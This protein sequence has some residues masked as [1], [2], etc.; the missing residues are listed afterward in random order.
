GVTGTNVINTSCYLRTRLQALNNYLFSDRFHPLSTYTFNRRGHL[1]KYIYSKETRLGGGEVVWQA[2]VSTASSYSSGNDDEEICNAPYNPSFHFPSADLAI[3]TNGCGTL[4]LLETGDRNNTNTWLEAF[5]GLAPAGEVVHSVLC[6]GPGHQREI[7]TL[8]LSV[9][10]LNTLKQDDRFVFMNSQL[11]NSKATALHLVHW[12]TL[13]YNGAVWEK[14]RER[15]LCGEG[16]LEYLSLNEA[17]TGILMLAHNNYSF[18]YDS[19]VKLIKPDTPIEKKLS[20][21]DFMYTQESDSV[22]IWVQLSSSIAKKDLNVNIK[23]SEMSISVQDESLLQG[24]FENAIKV[25]ESTWTISE[26][27]LELSLTKANESLQWKRVFRSSELVGEELLDPTMVEE[28]HQRLAH[29]TTDKLNANPDADKPA[30]NPEQLEACDEATDDLLL[31]RLD[32][33]THTITHHAQLGATQHLFNGQS[34]EMC[35]PNFCIRHDVDGL[36]WQPESA[37]SVHHVATFNAFG[38]VRA[39]KSM[40]KFTKAS[41]DNSYVAVADVKSHVYVFYQTDSLG[42]EIR[43]RKS[44]KRTSTVARQ[45]VISLKDHQEVLG[46]HACPNVIFVLTNDKLYSYT[47]QDV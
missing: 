3:A 39:S 42:S 1:I 31:L 14:N 8:I 2:D 12:I 28:I 29:L 41:P 9:T 44:G 35:V 24:E 30:F 10:T 36:V 20:K 46:L 18:I 19:Q 13:T 6:E 17:A 27:K 23:S 22:T 34:C 7:H 38:Y 40:A 45:L 33:Q 47:L 5:E 25:D 16:A 37:V 15:I 21:I 43:N 4:H 32:G 26:G 11:E